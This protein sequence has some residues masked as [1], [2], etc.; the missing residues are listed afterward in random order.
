[1]KIDINSVKKTKKTSIFTETKTCKISKKQKKW[2]R[3]NNICFTSFVRKCID[4]NMGD[5]K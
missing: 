4:D 1:M 2:F 5:E 3:K